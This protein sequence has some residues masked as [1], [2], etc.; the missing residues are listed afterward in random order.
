MTFCGTTCHSVWKTAANDGNTSVRT[1]RNP[2]EILKRTSVTC[3][4]RAYR[5]INPLCTETNTGWVIANSAL[6][7][8]CTLCNTLF[9]SFSYLRFNKSSVFR[10][11]VTAILK[12]ELKFTGRQRTRCFCHHGL[13]Y[14]TE[15]LEF[16]GSWFEFG[17]D[18]GSCQVFNVF[19]DKVGLTLT[20]ESPTWHSESTVH[21]HLPYLRSL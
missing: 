19:W 6:W 8:C 3:M 13:T 9:C 20:H 5:Y 17:P 12:S 15:A 2:T 16:G 4:S 1:A 7:I 10:R 21:H 11:N 14:N 18:I